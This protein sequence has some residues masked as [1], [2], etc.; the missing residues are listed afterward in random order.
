MTVERDLIITAFGDARFSL[1][2]QGVLAYQTSRGSLELFL[3]TRTGQERSID[4]GFHYTAF[5]FSPDGARLAAA[6]GNESG[7]N[8]IW[9][10]DLEQGG[11]RRVTTEGT[12]WVPTW[13]PDGEYLAFYSDRTGGY[14]LYRKRFD[15]TGSAELLL[16]SEDRQFSPEWSA[17]F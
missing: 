14:S 15:G 3:S 6:R 8:D 9:V 17:T 2:D 10:Y 1:C 11:S 12:N 16:D 5:S 7:E 13:S 4:R